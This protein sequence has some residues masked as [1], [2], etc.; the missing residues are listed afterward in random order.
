M[1]HN[2]V[3]AA[4]SVGDT[5][6]L[7][8]KWRATVYG[9]FRSLNDFYRFMTTPSAERVHFLQLCHVDHKFDEGVFLTI[10]S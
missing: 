7:Y 5:D 8:E 2:D 3:I 1:L 9:Q 4:P 6:S 10:Y